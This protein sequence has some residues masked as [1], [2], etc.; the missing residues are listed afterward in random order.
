MNSFLT[1]S[2]LSLVSILRIAAG[3]LFRQHGGEKLWGFAVGRIDH[4]FPNLHA[5]AGP[6]ELAG[7]ALM[8]LGL[9][10]RTTAFILCGG[11]ARARLKTCAPRRSLPSNNGGAGAGAFYRPQL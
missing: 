4:N 9:F 8:T 10:T 11:R 1:K 3:L 6:I 7:G 5:F 2:A